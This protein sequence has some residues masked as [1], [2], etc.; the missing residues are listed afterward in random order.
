MEVD[1]EV[2]GRAEALNEGDGAALATRRAPLAPCATAKRGEERTEKGAED[3]AGEASVV[4][5][6]VA[7][8]VGQRENPLADGDFRENAVDEARSGVGHSATSTRGAEATPLA[9]EGDEV[10]LAAGVA[11]EP[12]E[13]VSQDPAPEVPAK[14]LLDEAW[15]WPIGFPCAR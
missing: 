3:F 7:E 14:L 1:V 12:Q 6:A 4:G 13:A 10:V 11:A 8:R 15:C 5:T 2:Q 9:R